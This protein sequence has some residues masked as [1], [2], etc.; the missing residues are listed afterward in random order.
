MANHITPPPPCF[1]SYFRHF[2]F[3][4]VLSPI[5]LL[6]LLSPCLFF[7]SF[8]FT[9]NLFY[10]LPFSSI[11]HPFSL[12]HSTSLFS[13]AFSIQLSIHCFSILLFVI[14]LINPFTCNCHYF[15]LFITVFPFSFSFLPFLPLIPSLFNFSLF[16]SPSSYF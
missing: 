8:S 9:P 5:P 2:S 14:I 6:F 7:L 1:P 13:P 15:F 4:L 16:I 3:L 12:L 10:L 11:L